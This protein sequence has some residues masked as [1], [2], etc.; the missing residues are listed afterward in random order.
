MYVDIDTGKEPSADAMASA[1]RSGVAAQSPLSPE[2]VR[3]SELQ[4]RS[5][6]P[7]LDVVGCVPRHSLERPSGSDRP[8]TRTS[9][10]GWIERPSSHGVG[11]PSSS[12]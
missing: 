3:G 4:Q 8:I 2:R 11:S 6:A 9:E 7:D 12:G 10:N 1:R 5:A